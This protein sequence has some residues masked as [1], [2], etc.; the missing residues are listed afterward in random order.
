[1]PKE[2]VT[3]KELCGLPLDEKADWPG[4]ERSCLRKADALNIPKRQREGSRAWEYPVSALSEQTQFGLLAR[5]VRAERA[6]R[7]RAEREAKRTPNPDELWAWYERRPG[8]LKEEGIRRMMIV[9][10]MV[11]AMDEGRSYSV[12]RRTV[13]L[14]HDISEETLRRW[15]DVVKDA[16][17]HDWMALLV[18]HFSGRAV[19]APCSPDAWEFFKADYLRLEQP[20]AAACYERLKR[21]A[22]AYGWQVPSLKTLQRK[23]KRIPIK[24]RTLKREGEAAVLALYPPQQRKVAD[25]HALEW[26]NGDGYQH[27]VRVQWPDG[28]ITRPKTWFWQDIYSRKFLAWRTDTTEHTEVV[29]L[30]F[31]DL[32][33]KF[34]IPSHVTIDNTRAAANKW[35][36]GGM[37]NRY[38]FK[39]KA[40]EPA[41]VFIQLGVQ[42]H[43]T[44]VFKGKGHGQAKPIERAFGVG[45]IGEVV[46]KHPAFTGAWTGNNTQT[47]PEDYGRR[48]V[49]LATFL[50]VLNSEVN[51]FNAR[52]GRRTEIAGGVLS[53][54][55]V[56]EQSYRTAVIKKAR[57]DQRRLWLL[58][59]ENVT[60]QHGGSVTLDAGS[61]VGQGRNRYY[62]DALTEFVGNSVVVRFDPQD[63]HGEVHVYRPDGDYIATAV[64]IESAGFGDADAGRE[65]N[66]ARRAYL[67]ATKAQAESEQRMDALETARL[68]PEAPD[69][70]APTASVI[71]P[72]EL[73][74]P[75]NLPSPACGRGAGGEGARGASGATGKTSQSAS[76]RER[77]Q[78]T[79]SAIASRAAT[80]KPETQAERY[81]RWLGLDAHVKATGGDLSGLSEADQHWYSSYPNSAEY[82]TQKLM[83][84]NPAPCSVLPFQPEDKPEFAADDGNTAPAPRQKAG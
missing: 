55:Q 66:R 26:S 13:S 83:A 61:L 49:P 51:A 29:R 40:E 80:P 75:A 10:E 79:L 60:V 46:D 17:R 36:T 37:P 35:M 59:A 22:A 28:T 21:T 12:A 2:Y 4:T 44:S 77:A 42:V 76:A 16:E 7:I 43:W 69:P 72:A 78:A 14:A 53:F 5:E 73:S 9:Q 39:V 11:D 58:A 6:A 54:D 3:A 23:I 20:S 82:R 67:K 18:P 71:R 33:E 62:H 34:G 31:G 25:L 30:S 32:I 81:Q 8:S 63:L 1:M 65:H 70:V 38:R 68:L 74:S 56:F 47:K 19:E 64:C 24:V 52:L 45:G 48:A 50:E 15:W 84:D 41:G 57:P 27:N